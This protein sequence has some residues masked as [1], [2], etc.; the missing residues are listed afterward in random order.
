M[1]IVAP[2]NNNFRILRWSIP[3]DTKWIS[4]VVGVEVRTGDVFELSSGGLAFAVLEDRLTVTLYSDEKL[5]T[6]DT[7]DS[8]V[9]RGPGPV[10]KAVKTRY[11]RI[12][13]ESKSNT[14]LVRSVGRVLLREK[15]QGSLL[16]PNTNGGT[17]VRTITN[18]NLI[19]RS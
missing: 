13:D 10:D 8:V 1:S 3:Y 6:M 18:L 9:Q 4:K 16:F 15:E 12:I 7:I 14:S 19:Q 2:L 17:E 11:E 5:T